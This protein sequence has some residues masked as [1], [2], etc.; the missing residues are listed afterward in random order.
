MPGTTRR[1]RRGPRLRDARHR[2]PGLRRRGRRGLPAA[3]GAQLMKGACYVCEGAASIYELCRTHWEMLPKPLRD[4]LHGASLRDTTDV[5]HALLPGIRIFLQHRN[6]EILPAEWRYVSLVPG[7]RVSSLGQVCRPNG[8]L[9]PWLI[10]TALYPMVTLD[11]R[12]RYFVHLL[13]AEAFLGPR[14]KGHEVDHRD[15]NSLNPARENLR[16]LTMTDNSGRARRRARLSDLERVEI[17]RLAADHSVHFLAARFDITAQ[18]ARIVA[19]REVALKT[20]TLAKREAC[21]AEN[22]GKSRPK[23]GEP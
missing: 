14:P 13:V 23:E 7:A 10:N 20:G 22:R 18:T 16:Y 11:G 6:G 21:L 19:R 5:L 17:R 12:K 15:R 9:A 4:R 1:E 8:R 2:V 3:R